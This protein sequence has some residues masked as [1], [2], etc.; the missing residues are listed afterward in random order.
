MKKIFLTGFLVFV[1]TILFSPAVLA[2]NKAKTIVK[3]PV[4]MAGNIQLVDKPIDGDLMISGKE[5]KITSDINGDAY[6]GGGQVEINGNVN[7]SLIVAGGRVTISGKVLKNLIVAGGQVVVNDSAKVGGYVLAGGKNINL[8]GNFLG[9]V[10]LGA[11]NLIVGEKAIING[12]LEANV[13]KSEISSNSKIVGEKKIQI[14]E[15][16]KIEKQPNRW[17][18]MGYAKEIFSFLSKLIILLVLIKLF[19]QKIKSWDIANSFWGSIGLGL[20]VLVVTPFLVLI[21]MLTVLAI[22]LSMIILVTY[23]V[24]LCLS[25]ILA[26]ILVGKYIAEKT[27]LKAN[28]YLQGFIGLVLVT[29]VG[30]IPFIGCFIKFIILLL[31]IG[32][33]FKN[34]RL[35]FIK[36]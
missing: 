19:G 18:Q 31:G 17:L 22:P 36:K 25:G 33:V 6:V 23:L 29:V 34:L 9:P 32:I 8:Y 12:N 3:L 1:F 27:N 2:Q 10:K 28:I 5:I 30:L 4:F 35:A 13:A 20:V 15:I 16:K 7:G 21:L 11:E 26:S 14:Y 24:G